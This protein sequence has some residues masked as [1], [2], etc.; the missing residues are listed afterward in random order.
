MKNLLLL[1]CLFFSIHNL[2]TA[3]NN[4]SRASNSSCG[5]EAWFDNYCG[6]T[7][8][9][10]KTLKVEVYAKNYHRI[11]Y[12]ELYINGDYVG[13]ETS[14]PYDW[15]KPGKDRHLK[16][17]RAGHYKMKVKIV[18]HCGKTKYI[19]YCE[20]E[21]KRRPTHGGHDPCD[22]H[23]LDWIKKINQKYPDHAIWEYTYNGDTYFKVYRCG[24]SHYTEYWYDCSGHKVCEFQN[25]KNRKRLSAPC[26]LRICLQWSYL[27]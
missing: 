23:D 5:W 3:Q 20:Y 10:G 16:N 6:K 26:Y 12:M 19:D 1:F 7:Y 2:V 9:E 11:K 4:Q 24:Q 17:M 21:V 14:H 13:K 15:G 25:G 8:E 27:L 18:D 22:Y